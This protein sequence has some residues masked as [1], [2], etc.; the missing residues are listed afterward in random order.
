MAQLPVNLPELTDAE[1]AT[2]RTSFNAIKTL[3]YEKSTH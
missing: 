3:S 1:L 2:L